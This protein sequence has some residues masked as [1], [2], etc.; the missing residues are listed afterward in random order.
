MYPVMCNCFYF[1]NFREKPLLFKTDKKD[2]RNRHRKTVKF[3][4]LAMYM[5]FGPLY[6]K[7]KKKS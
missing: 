4:E 2:K 3:A 6:E 1:E 5:N 7:I